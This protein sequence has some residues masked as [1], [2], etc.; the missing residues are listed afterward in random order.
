M[1]VCAG[2]RPPASKKTTTAGHGPPPFGVATSVVHGPSGVVSWILLVVMDLSSRCSTSDPSR[3]LNPATK[4]AQW[5]AKL[6]IYPFYRHTA[7]MIL[8][9]TRRAEK[10]TQDRHKR[11][12]ALAT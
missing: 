1:R 4:M 5:E 2:R 6:A 9:T 12:E 11:C 10:G 8:A 7:A 3:G